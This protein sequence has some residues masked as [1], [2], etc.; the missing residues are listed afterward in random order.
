MKVSEKEFSI[1]LT[2]GNKLKS[3]SYTFAV[4]NAGKIQHD[5]AIEGNGIKETKTPLIDAG[6][7]KSLSVDLKPGKYTFYCTVPGHEQ[8]GMKVAVTVGGGAPAT[9][10]AKQPAA[11]PK[12]KA[13]AAK[14]VGVTEKEFSI[15]LAGGQ[16]LTAG[17]YAFDVQNQG[18]IQHDLAIDGDGLKGKKTKLIDGGKSAKLA[19]D[20]QAGQ[21]QV[22]LQRSG[23]RAGRHE[24][25]GHRQ[26]AMDGIDERA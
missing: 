3:G 12:K 16:S 26:V 13:A 18:K 6:Q 14:A 4:D 17:K 2:G 22:L 24:A 15:A 1:A 21:I 25:P 11:K 10:A 8:S 9:P 23:P 7:S 5:L 19:V 20:S